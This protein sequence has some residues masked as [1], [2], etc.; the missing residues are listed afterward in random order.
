MEM[1]MGS[2]ARALGLMGFGVGEKRARVVRRATLAEAAMADRWFAG[3]MVARL[4]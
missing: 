4:G 3:R 1:E 2:G